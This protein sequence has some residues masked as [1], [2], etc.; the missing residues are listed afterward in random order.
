MYA[1]KAATPTHYS[2]TSCIYELLYTLHS[3]TGFPLGFLPSSLSHIPTFA[4]TTSSA[5]TPAPLTTA[6]LAGQTAASTLFNIPSASNSAT[7]FATSLPPKLIKK[8][9]DLEFIDMAELVP[10]AWQQGE[11]TNTGCCSRLTPK[12]GPVTD[13]LLWVE[14][15]SILAGVLTTKYPE[16][17][18]DLMA[19][20]KTIVHASRSF[21]GEHWVTYD[22]CY[23]RQAAANK[24]LHWAQIDFSLYN[25]T[26]TGRAKTLPRCRF[27]LS[28]YHR[29]TDCFFAPV[30][31]T[32]Y[33]ATPPGA[34]VPSYAACS[35]LGPGTT[36]VS[37]HVRVCISAATVG[38]H[39]Q[40]RYADRIGNR[41][42]NSHGWT[43]AHRESRRPLDTH[44]HWHRTVL[45]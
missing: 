11:D 17:A 4:M 10:D 34:L 5:T 13:I 40:H 42:R 43:T 26:F 30:P 1:R 2:L 9:L 41:H 21:A 3:T 15:Y 23:R 38:S 45:G 20:Q 36:V 8:I 25:E 35:M 33:Q 31:P 14:C 12:R 18:P 24:S 7:N 39:I 29:S 6:A 27:C 44:M 28:E 19:Y 22:M 32:R 16:R 37:A